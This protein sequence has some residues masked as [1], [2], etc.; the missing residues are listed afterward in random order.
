[1]LIMFSVLGRAVLCPTC[2]AVPGGRSEW[3]SSSL[4]GVP[5]RLVRLCGTVGI[6][7]K[8]LCEGGVVEPGPT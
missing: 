1:M 5:V 3:G 2:M 7:H 6:W 4:L 8:I